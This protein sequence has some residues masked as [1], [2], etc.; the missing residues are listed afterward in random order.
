MCIFFK[1]ELL[2]YFIFL[3]AKACM[4]LPIIYLCCIDLYC[5]KHDQKV[6]QAC[7]SL[8]IN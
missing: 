8:F 4:N 7:A 5:W 6:N 3:F 2:P 1:N